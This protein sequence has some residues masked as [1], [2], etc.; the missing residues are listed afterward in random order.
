M[1]EILA[2]DE[3][4]GAM[5]D[6]ARGDGETLAIVSMAVGALIGVGMAAA[7]G[8]TLYLLVLCWYTC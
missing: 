8:A 3:A 6:F 7:L 5:L 1:R 2:Y 4:V